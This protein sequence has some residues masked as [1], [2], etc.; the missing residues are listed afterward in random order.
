[1][2]LRWQSARLITSRSQDRSLAS[3]I[4]VFFFTRDHK[5]GVFC[6]IFYLYDLDRNNSLTSL[7]QLAPI[8]AEQV[9][10]LSHIIQ[11]HFIRIFLVYRRNGQ[12]R[13]Q[14]IAM[15]DVF[16]LVFRVFSQ[17]LLFLLLVHC[18]AQSG[19]DQPE[20]VRRRRNPRDIHSI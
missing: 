17:C 15:L 14:F 9:F 11:F 6:F 13:I 16:V 18:A 2:E 12:Q 10:A 19:I 3:R 1:M 7:F 8:F 5:K 4:F 20:G